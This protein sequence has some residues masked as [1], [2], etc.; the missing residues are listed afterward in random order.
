[1]INLEQHVTSLGLSKKLKAIGMPQESIF[2]WVYLKESDEH[3]VQTMGEYG[4]GKIQCSAYTASELGLYIP[5]TLDI[6]GR[7]YLLQI[8]HNKK[9]VWWFNLVGFPD[10]IKESFS[11][12]ETNSRAA[13]L[14]YLLENGFME[15][16]R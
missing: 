4:Y 11:M 5:N 13:C 16:P 12:N 9:K 1:M 10:Y 15:L 8:Y 2:Y 3:I 6:D 14:I 7:T